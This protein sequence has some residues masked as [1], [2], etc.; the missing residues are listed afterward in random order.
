VAI[1]EYY[2]IHADIPRTVFWTRKEAREAGEKLAQLNQAQPEPPAPVPTALE[3]DQKTRIKAKTPPAPAHKIVRYFHRYSHHER[4]KDAVGEYF[5]V[6][7][8]FPN[9]SFNTR[10][11]AMDA[12]GRAAP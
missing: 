12:G 5:Y 3:T 8:D 7:T 9:I 6:N 1:G 10:K 2:Y 11:D 4:R